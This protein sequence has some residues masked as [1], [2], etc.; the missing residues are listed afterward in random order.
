M[1]RMVMVTALLLA[2]CATSGEPSQA[3]L[4]AQW[5]AQNVPPT[6]Y[7][8]DLIAFMRTYLNDPTGVRGASVSAPQ[9]KTI[10]SDPGERYVACVRYDAR[11]T[12]GAYAGMKTGAAVYVL[13]KLDRFIEIQLQTQAICK[14][15]AY[16]PFPELQRLRR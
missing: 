14:D 4:R 3:D 9:R 6:N 13:G 8:A 7:K 10:G 12:D 5:E 15:V 16:E 2:G 11:K 1:R